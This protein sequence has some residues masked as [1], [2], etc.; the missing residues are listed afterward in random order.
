MIGL[1]SI[2][3]RQLCSRAG[4]NSAEQWI[5]YG[6]CTGLL[7]IVLQT[8]TSWAAHSMW[9]GCLGLNLGLRN[10]VSLQERLLVTPFLPFH[11]QHGACN[12]ARR[13]WLLSCEHC[14]IRVYVRVIVSVPRVSAVALV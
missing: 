10:E 7:I 8:G 4:C 14:N 6:S 11:L 12:T 2:T 9:A 3:C 1:C 5:R 13:C